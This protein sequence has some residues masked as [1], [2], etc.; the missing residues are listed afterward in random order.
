MRNIILAFF[1][2]VVCLSCPKPSQA[3]V[4]DSSSV[5]AISA[6]RL[7]ATAGVDYAW[8]E[9]KSPGE[10]SAPGVL[11]AQ[12][13]QF[14]LNLAYSLGNKSSLIGAV[15]YGSK[16]K[17]VFARVGWRVVLFRGR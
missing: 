14:N 1:L 6:K 8:Y 15:A 2:A 11:P 4:A 9:S 10:Q 3:Q 7:L 16:S 12:E 5:P 13:P 17:I